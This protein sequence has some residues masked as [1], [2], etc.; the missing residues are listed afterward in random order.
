MPPDFAWPVYDLPEGL[1]RL[2]RAPGELATDIPEDGW[3]TSRG[4]SARALQFVAQVDLAELRNTPLAERWPSE[5]R[6]YLFAETEFS[7]EPTPDWPDLARIGAA[8]AFLDFSSRASLDRRQRPQSGVMSTPIAPLSMSFTPTWILPPQY[9]YYEPPIDA[10]A[11]AADTDEHALAVPT[12]LADATGKMWFSRTHYIGGPAR[13]AGLL[14]QY[15]TEFLIA[16]DGMVPDDEIESF[17]LET[18]LHL[19]AGLVGGGLAEC[20]TF[21]VPTSHLR[22]GKLDSMWVSGGFEAS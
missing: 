22:V 14:D 2:W 20:L 8:A 13:A 4:E 16:R 15:E 21:L 3:S 10:D 12:D 9:E 18:L 5:G 19:G 7:L 6:I 11:E 17:E 1:M